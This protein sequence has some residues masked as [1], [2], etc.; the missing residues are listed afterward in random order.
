MN[1]LYLFMAIVA[2]IFG[3]WVYGS[4]TAKAVCR[5]QI[6][7]QN[8]R[9]IQEAETKIINTKR[10]IHDTVYKTGVRDIRNILRDKYT[11]AE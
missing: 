10:M 11:I 4:E 9:E 1:K 6:A 5:A 7:N 8:L 2:L 3:A